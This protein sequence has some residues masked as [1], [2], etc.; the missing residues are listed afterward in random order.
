VGQHLMVGSV[1]QR[2]VATG[3]AHRHL[4]IVWHHQC[5]EHRHKERRVFSP[6]LGLAYDEFQMRLP[7]LVM[8]TELRAAVT[9]GGMRGAILFPEQWALS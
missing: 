5:T 6:V 7:V 9:I 8:K 2:L 1:Q 3:L 4:S